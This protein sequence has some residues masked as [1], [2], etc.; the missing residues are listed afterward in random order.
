LIFDWSAGSSVEGVAAAGSDWINGL[1][2]W[3][4]GG[5][6]SIFDF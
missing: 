3:W 6:E 5:A 4:I 2:D 1:V